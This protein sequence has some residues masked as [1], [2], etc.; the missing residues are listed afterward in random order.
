M[1]LA[2]FILLPFLL[3]A[4]PARSDELR[5]GYIGLVQKD[6]T[7]WT[8]D[9]RQPYLEG[10][11]ARLIV[12]NLPENC[13]ISGRIKRK[14][15]AG[16]VE[17]TS[18]LVCRGAIFGKNI[19]VSDM[20]QSSEM[21]VRIAAQGKPVQF[22]RLTPSGPSVTIAGGTQAHR[23]FASYLKLGVEH[24]LTGWD[25][26]LFVVA[27]V[28]LVR[29]PAPVIKAATAFTLAHSLTL[30][31]T[32]LGFIGLPQRP[33][34]AL[35]AL[36]I[37][38]LALEIVKGD[39]WQDSFA[40]RFPW[41]VSFLFGLVHGFG[42]AGALHEIGLPEGE[43]PISLFA[44]NIG[45]ELGQLIIIGAVIAV[46][47]IIERLSAKTIVPAMRTAAYIIGITSS[48]WLIDRL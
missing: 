27:L 30:A 44:F 38:F 42:F 34:E 19:G 6:A 17:G 45:V 46:Q 13:G 15:H 12:P 33:V 23:L 4:A 25:H 18:N 21:L 1:R 9:W 22:Y 5:P 28:L 48:Y 36:S 2:F 39:E 41:V 43:V 24:I 32:T 40:R 20:G 7:H 37:I 11:F 3:C 8:V 14:V 16:S 47:R 29:R 10:G 31:G 35:I 26:L